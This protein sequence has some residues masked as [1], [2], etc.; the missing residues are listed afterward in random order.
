MPVIE[1]DY[2]SIY[3]PNCAVL[4]KLDTNEANNIY[5]FNKWVRLN[6]GGYFLKSYVNT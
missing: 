5:L 4:K 3:Y 1:M 2:N 6:M